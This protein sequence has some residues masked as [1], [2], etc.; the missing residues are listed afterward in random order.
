MELFSF[1]RNEICMGCSFIVV[2]TYVTSLTDSWWR[3]LSYRNQSIDLQS[4]LMDW[5]LYDSYL[6][7]EKINLPETYSKT[8]LNI[9]NGA[10][11]EKCP[12]REFF[13]VR[14]FLYLDW[15]PRFTE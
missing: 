5:C 12:N 11:R 4:K 15:I 2:S 7:H 8:Q 13:L 9:W 1:F 3:S 14:I 6:R 10:L